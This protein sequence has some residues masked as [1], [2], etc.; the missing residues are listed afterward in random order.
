MPLYITEYAEL[1]R[2]R[3]SFHIA[4]G[5][6]PAIAGQEVAVG[7]GSVESAAFNELTAFVMVHA[8]EAAHIKF[9]LASGAVTAVTTA[10]RMAAGETRF[11]GVPPG[12][13]YQ[14]AVI[15]G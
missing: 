10:H 8:E 7:A 13:L 5:L 15:A 1:A 14:L 3:H 9:G 11:Y 4:A 6:E 2:D 12:G